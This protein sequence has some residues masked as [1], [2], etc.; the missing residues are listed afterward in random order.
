MNSYGKT[1]VSEVNRKFSLHK[2]T[3]LTSNPKWVVPHWTWVSGPVQERLMR[4]GVEIKDF[5]IDPWDVDELEVVAI[6]SVKEDYLI[7][8]GV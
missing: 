4:I 5:D 6:A 7:R 8:L 3:M 2:K 1:Y